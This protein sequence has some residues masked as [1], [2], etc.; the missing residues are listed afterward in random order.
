MVNWRRLLRVS[1]RSFL[2][3]IFFFS[4]STTCL[5]FIYV[6]PGIANT[7]FFMVQAQGIMLRDN[8]RTIG[9]MIRLYTNKNSTLNGT[10]YPDGSNSSEYMVQPTTYLPENFTYGQNLPCPERLPSMKG[11]IDVN[12]TEIP[13]EEIDLK[14]SK[15]LDVQFGGHWKPKDCK[16]RW[17][18]AILIPFRNRHEHLPI[19]FQHLTPI[20]Q[21]QR[22]QFAYYVIEQSG[23][24]PF[25]R[26]MLF[27]VGFLEAMKDL[28]W[29]CL[30]FHDVDH[31]P[32]ND[33]NYYGCGQMPRHFA[34]KLDKYMYL[35]P[36][37]EFFGG[38]SGL[39][40]E[41]FRKINGFPNAF[42]GWGGEDDDL[43]NRVRYA[44]L[45]V[46]R[47]EGEMG[48]YK[49]IPHHHRGEVQFLGRYK[50]LRY[51][52]ERQHL[53]GLNNLN[54]TPEISLSS[55]YKNI[56]VDLHPDLAPITDY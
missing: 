42:W 5:Y 27:N 40:V 39:T 2:A 37:S 15:Y 19:L 6:A 52:K 55:L 4:M 30:V 11:P 34:A 26:A 35:L 3:L 44:G 53:D 45:N 9:Q 28:D 21:R 24:Q 20:L 23:T 10:D 32:E 12:M 48:K 22:L 36:Y 47:P 7:Y 14:F 51:S 25:N 46:T 13:M 33:R 41:Q 49:S 54:Y 8:V 17:K 1:N 50:L 18:V 43:W 56:T 31:I 16:P 29:D 38:V